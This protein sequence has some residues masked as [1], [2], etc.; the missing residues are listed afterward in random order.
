MDKRNGPLSGILAIA[1]GNTKALGQIRNPN[2]QL[3]DE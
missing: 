1:I 3:V 2:H